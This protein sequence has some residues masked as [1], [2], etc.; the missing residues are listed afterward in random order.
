MGLV[1]YWLIGTAEQTETSRNIIFGAGIAL[2]LMGSLYHKLGKKKLTTGSKM[3][4]S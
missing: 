1:V 2:Y 4:K 3:E